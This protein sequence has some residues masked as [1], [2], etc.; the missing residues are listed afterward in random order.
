MYAC[1]CGSTIKKSSL[2][3]HLQSKKHKKFISCPICMEDSQNGSKE[4]E[5]CHNK[6]CTKCF[7]QIK[8]FR[9]PFCR[10]YLLTSNQTTIYQNHINYIHHTREMI[11]NCLL[12]PVNQEYKENTMN[13]I[14]TLKTH[15][16][17]VNNIITGDFDFH[18]LLH[19]YPE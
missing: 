17:G 1:E 15:G 13:C 5:R 8:N 9:C 18:R 10:D 12:H 6:I 7:F 3:Q 11:L 16:V 4:C 14:N 19:R 2:R